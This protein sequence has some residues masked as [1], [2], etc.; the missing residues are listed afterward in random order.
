MYYPVFLFTQSPCFLVDD[1]IF[2][3]ESPCK[4][5]H[6]PAVE[7][8]AHGSDR[9]EEVRVLTALDMMPQAL[10][11]HSTAGHNAVKV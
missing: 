9:K 3:V 6:E 5:I 4:H 10:L 8:V 7:F 2:L 1:D 11:I